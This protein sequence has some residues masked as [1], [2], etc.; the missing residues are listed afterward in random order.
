MRSPRCELAVGVP[1]LAVAS[2]AAA[3]APT[4]RLHVFL[5]QGEQ[6][7][8]VTRPGSTP[9]GAVRQLIA[10]RPGPSRSVDFA[11]LCHARSD[12]AA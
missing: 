10:A 1:A 2:S 3:T 12:S 11:R 8:P 4:R 5:L 6:R 7:A 9:A